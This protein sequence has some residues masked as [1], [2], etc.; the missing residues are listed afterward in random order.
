MQYG[1]E[2]SQL[3]GVASIQREKYWPPSK[4]GPGFIPCLERSMTRYSQVSARSVNAITAS[5]C[6]LPPRPCRSMG[7][8]SGY[9]ENRGARSPD[10]CQAAA[11]KLL[12][13]GTASSL[14]AG[15]GLSIR[16]GLYLYGAHAAR[17]LTPRS[18]VK[19]S[20]EGTMPPP[21]GVPAYG[22]GASNPGEG[23]YLPAEAAVDPSISAKPS[24]FWPLLRSRR[25]ILAETMKLHGPYGVVRSGFH[26]CAAE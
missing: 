4:S 8:I 5:K 22:F 2:M 11:R 6:K 1:P 25:W 16:K 3:C 12:L 18:T 13:S 19:A 21:S 17:Q 14:G 10:V 9:R 20:S 7:T 24:A 23:T 15:K 26:F